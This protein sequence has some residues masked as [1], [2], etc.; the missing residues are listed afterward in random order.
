MNPSDDYMKRMLEHARELQDKIGQAIGESDKFRDA[1]VEQARQSA[2]ATHEQTK[3]AI[4]NLES[5]MKT[6]SEAIARFMRD[7]KV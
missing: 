4:D 7:G 1:L 6:G 5:A 2:D 3:A